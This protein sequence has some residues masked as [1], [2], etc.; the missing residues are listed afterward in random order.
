MPQYKLPKKGG[1]TMDIQIREQ[2]LSTDRLRPYEQ[3]MEK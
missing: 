1:Q 3:E 2:Y